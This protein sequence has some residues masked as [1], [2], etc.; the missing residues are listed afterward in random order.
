MNNA[1][2]ASMAEPRG[3][4]AMV[5]KGGIERAV[6]VNADEHKLGHTMRDGVG[7]PTDNNLA[8]RSLAAITDDY[9]VK[10]GL[11]VGSPEKK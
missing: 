2:F 4:Y 1:S 9:S 8:R 7:K 6:R 3:D 10:F 5:A 11:W